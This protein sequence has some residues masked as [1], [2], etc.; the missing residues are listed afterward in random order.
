MS[1]ITGG[2]K[3]TIPPVLINSIPDQKAINVNT[4]EFSFLFDEVINT[5]EIKSKLIISPYSDIKYEVD[6][7]KNSLIL[8]FDSSFENNRTY[9]FN[10]ADGIKDITEGNEAKTLKYV[11]ST[12]PILDSLIVFGEVAVSYTHQTLPTILLV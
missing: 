6:A 2:E 7:K 3:D 1:V 9:I 12:G 5:D 4:K 11:F 8:S 10:F